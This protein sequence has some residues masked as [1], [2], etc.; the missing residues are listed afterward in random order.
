[1]RSATCQRGQFTVMGSIRAVAIG[2]GWQGDLDQVVGETVEADGTRHPVTL[3]EAL[4]DTLVAAHF[5]IASPPR[6]S[7]RAAEAP[8]APSEE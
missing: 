8:A 6:T 1:M 2:P 4:G 5:E 7:R 3:A